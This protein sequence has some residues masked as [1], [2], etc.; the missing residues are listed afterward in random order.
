MTTKIASASLSVT[1]SIACQPKGGKTRADATLSS[2][3]S[4]VPFT[5][6]VPYADGIL[7]PVSG[8]IKATGV[9]RWN[10]YVLWSNF[11]DYRGQPQQIKWTAPLIDIGEV[12]WFTIATDAEFDGTCTYEISTSETGSFQGEETKT[13]V[14]EGDYDITAFYG[15]YV[16]VTAIVTGNELRRLN[17]TTASTVKTFRLRDI[18]SSTLDGTISARVIPL[19]QPISRVMNI[20]IAPKVTTAYAVDLYVSSSATSDLVIP[21]V[22]SKAD[23]EP[24]FITDYIAT[25][26]FV[27]GAT[28]SFVLYG[29]D[30]Q[31][32][33]AT[34]DI[35]LECLPR[36]IMTSGNMVTID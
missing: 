21:M 28:P 20:V 15:R 29:I 25:D 26:Y 1:S 14:V 27:A 4:M 18:D 23:T 30:N 36:Q 32:R 22:I 5:A 11:S 6:F 12:K 16:Y 7:D 31:P 8:T 34:V 35:T 13:T 33:D 9:S 3:F 10:N 24:Y 2:V 19:P 17:I